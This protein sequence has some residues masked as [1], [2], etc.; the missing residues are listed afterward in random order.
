MDI[1]QY[2]ELS[3]R[4]KQVILERADAFMDGRD[5]LTIEDLR[6]GWQRAVGSSASRVENLATEVSTW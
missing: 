4:I 1:V 6:I 5:G 2:V 3:K